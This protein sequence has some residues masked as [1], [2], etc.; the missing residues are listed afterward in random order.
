QLFGDS[1]GTGG[2]RMDY[3][4]DHQLDAARTP[5]PW[6]RVVTEAAPREHIVQLYQ[7]QDFLNRAVCRFAGAALANGEGIILVPTL[8]HWNAFRP[9]LEA[10]GVDVDAARERGQLT[11][12]DAD[13]T[14]PR[15]MR[16]GMPDSP[17]FL[18]LAAEVIRKARAGGRYK[19]V[20]WWGEMV[21][22]LWERGDVAASMNL[23]DLFDQLGEEQNV[24]LFC[25]FLMDNFDGEVHTHMLPRL[26]TN[27]SHLI[28]VEDYARLERAV[29]DA[30]RETVG[31]DRARVLEDRLLSDYRE[32]FNM[33]R[34]QALLLA[35]RQF[36]PTVA[37]PVLLRSRNLYTAANA[38]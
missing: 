7:D 5:E 9:R 29:A 2:N 23:E 13:E 3:A 17:V 19:T 31:A 16:D 12:V 15:F 30:L 38:A 26:G 25:S 32:P 34:G 4:P 6:D 24:A 8:R 11:V 33:P 20:R 28:P 1:T 27:H 14:L 37:D 10:E 21:N 18:G 22:V 35:L 36:H